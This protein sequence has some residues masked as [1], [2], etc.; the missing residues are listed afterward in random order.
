MSRSLLLAHTLAVVWCCAAIE[1]SAQVQNGSDTTQDGVVLSKLS[2]PIY[3]PLAKQAR[4]WGDVNLTVHVR[5][6]GSV[7]SVKLDSGPAMLKQAALD[8]ALKSEFVCRGCSEAL[9]SYSLVYTFKF[10]GKKCCAETDNGTEREKPQPRA[11]VIQSQNQVTILADPACICDPGP[12]RK[13]RSAKCF[14]LWRC[15][16]R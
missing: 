8:S 12:D 7:E 5:K 1:L 3:P 14:Y 16:F 4:V 15:S 10:T 9:T 11:G 6:D 13:V 2:T